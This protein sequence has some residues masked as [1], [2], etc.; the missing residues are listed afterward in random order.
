MKNLKRS[1]IAVLFFCLTLFTF[2]STD[3]EAGTTT[4]NGYLTIQA[5]EVRIAEHQEWSVTFTDWKGGTY[6]V[7]FER[8]RG[9]SWET[10]MTN[11]TNAA[12]FNNLVNEV[13]LGSFNGTYSNIGFTNQTFRD[14]VLGAVEKA[15][16][17]KR[18]TINEEIA[19]KKRLGGG[20]I[21]YTEVAITGAEFAATG[22]GSDYNKLW[23]LVISRLAGAP[24]EYK[25]LA[26]DHS[27][28]A[29]LIQNTANSSTG[30][31]TLEQLSAMLGGQI[32]IYDET[33]TGQNFKV[34]I[35]MLV[36]NWAGS[37]ESHI[38]FQNF[39]NECYGGGWPVTSDPAGARSNAE[40]WLLSKGVTALNSGELFNTGTTSGQYFSGKYV[41]GFE[42]D[43][44]SVG[45]T[46]YAV[47]EPKK[48]PVLGPFN[49]SETATFKLYLNPDKNLVNGESGNYNITITATPAG[50]EISL[51]SPSFTPTN[52]ETVGMTTTTGNT[53]SFA[54]DKKNLNRFSG[55]GTGTSGNAYVTVQFPAPGN[56]A[57][58]GEQSGWASFT[59][60][61]VSAVNGTIDWS[62]TSSSKDSDWDGS[63]TKASWVPS[64]TPP[65]ASDPR[66]INIDWELHTAGSPTADGTLVGNEYGSE[67]WEATTAIPSTENVS[68][69][70]G[71][72]TSM[73]DANG[74]ITATIDGVA[75][76]HGGPIDTVWTPAP[77]PAVTRKVKVTSTVSNIWGMFNP[78]DQLSPTSA[79]KNGGSSWSCGHSGVSC[80]GNGTASHGR[81]EHGEY[82]CPMHPQ[83]SPN[84]VFYRSQ[85]IAGPCN[86]GPPGFSPI[87]GGPDG[88]TQIGES[89]NSESCGCGSCGSH[90]CKW[91]FFVTDGISGA[92]K[93]RED[94]AYS[95][96]SAFTANWINDNVT[97]YDI[98]PGLVVKGPHWNYSGEDFINC[99]QGG[100]FNGRV[101]GSINWIPIANQYYRVTGNVSSNRPNGTEYVSFS[102]NLGSGEPIHQGY[103]MGMGSAS[104]CYENM[105]HPGTH[106]YSI[107]YVETIGNYAYR[108]IANA[109]VYSLMGSELSNIH[110]IN[111]QGGSN[112]G[113]QGAPIVD[114]AAGQSVSAPDMF[115]SLW[116]CLKG[117]SGQ[118][119]SGSGRI[120]FEAWANAGGAPSGVGISVSKDYFL[121]DADVTLTITCDHLYA[122]AC[123]A[124][125]NNGASWVKNISRPNEKN[126][127]KTMNRIHSNYVSSSVTEYLQNE[128]GDALT[129]DWNPPYQYYQDDRSS[130]EYRLR[131][132]SMQRA[133]ANYWQ[134]INSNEGKN[135]YTAN[136]ISDTLCYG[137]N[138]NTTVVVGDIYGVDGGQE[139]VG[140]FNFTMGA[141]EDKSVMDGSKEV[142][143]NHGVSYSAM[144]GSQ[145]AQ[146]MKGGEM[147]I[148]SITDGSHM[149]YFGYSTNGM[150]AYDG[151]DQPYASSL[152]GALR[153]GTL[154]A[155][156]GAGPGVSLTKGD[157]VSSG[158]F[159]GTIDPS[160]SYG[161]GLS[162][163]TLI[164]GDSGDC[165][166]SGNFSGYWNDHQYTGQHGVTFTAKV[167]NGAPVGSFS[168]TNC[169]KHNLAEY[170]SSLIISNLKLNPY[171]PNGSWD[172]CNAKF[173]YVKTLTAQSTNGASA[174]ASSLQ[175]LANKVSLPAHDNIA[176]NGLN[177]QLP[178]IYIY[179]PIST[180]FSQ[181]IGN[182]YGN[183]SGNA[184]LTPDESKYD[185]RVDTENVDPSLVDPYTT[186]T[187]RTQVWITPIGDMNLVDGTSMSTGS[188][189]SSS[190]TGE[191]YRNSGLK[192][193]SKNMNVE[194]WISNWGIKYPHVT[195][196][197][198]TIGE[199]INSYYSATGINRVYGGFRYGPTNLQNFKEEPRDHEFKYGDC[200]YSK[201][202]V[203][204]NEVQDG[205]ISVVAEASNYYVKTGDD[206]AQ[207][208]FTSPTEFRNNRSSNS[209]YTDIEID[210]VGSIGNLAIHD[211]TD[212]RYSNF[213]K[214]NL[215]EYLITGT[216]KKV[217]P[218][219]PLKIVSSAK[220]ILE[221]AVERD[222]N[223][224][225]GKRTHAT[226]GVTD[227][228]IKKADGTLEY[229]YGMGGPYEVLPLV[230]AYNT[231]KE[232]KSEA[233]RLG[234]KV[235]ASVDTVGNYQALIDDGIVYPVSTSQETDPTKDT[236]TQYLE[237]KSHYYLYDFD[238]GKFYAIDLWSGG[239][240]QKSRIYNG[241]TDEVELSR[242]SEAL[243]VNMDEEVSRRNISDTEA[244]VSTTNAIETIGPTAIGA[245][246]DYT[247]YTGH[248]KLDNRNLTYN[249]S[250]FILGDPY[251]ELLDR[252]TQVGNRGQRYHFTQGLTSSTSA[253]YHVDSNDQAVIEAATQ[254]L[255][256]E[257]PHAVIV[258]FNDFIAHGAVWTIRLH[259]SQVNSPTIKF[260]SDVADERPDWITASSYTETTYQ[261]AEVYDRGGTDVLYTIDKELTP[262]VTYEAYKTAADD[263]AVSGT[264]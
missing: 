137:N 34:P 96:L 68:A 141:L 24:T 138:A 48:D 45:G 162:G 5:T 86:I 109:V 49:T 22:N 54:V 183:W 31:D 227:Y 60:Q 94:G 200:F 156:N 213:F 41:V 168:A 201:T 61:S 9:D 78:P 21:F 74:W 47:G 247:G 43:T 19:A 177:I 204:L 263:R 184:S 116:R 79:S 194:R 152:P 238:D 231:I 179:N 20:E 81:Q 29:D 244:S 221:E 171:T 33:G 44:S 100:D 112:D 147:S 243:Y 80:S 144:S 228:Y 99:S 233:V 75:G 84:G 206:T 23:N 250:D 105:V 150:N 130:A 223:T 82:Q 260:F 242:N 97:T 69:V 165:G 76:A 232:F 117:S 170:G 139:G 157:G 58:D 188:E 264:H 261:D 111:F 89:P 218:T 92:N 230:P 56:G 129:E 3:V 189:G 166:G 113:T 142:Y 98:T 257:H 114:S 178:P 52:F 26:S 140:L 107:T 95:T 103:T 50:G 235:L 57:N 225:D 173:H 25:G 220:D 251:G 198:D 77:K 66:F 42:V 211:T 262:L 175:A 180:E 226:L 202:T 127:G 191:V 215:D 186:P 253:S 132:T 62:G 13:C 214:K 59:V 256:E 93:G 133:T 14:M 195:K 119:E 85:H 115:G 110:K 38:S 15:Y 72:E 18:T 207:Y 182:E 185:Y 11:P 2:Y 71:A 187:R 248:L 135:T 176:A 199:D 104:T 10:I 146:L 239:S 73:I 224:R 67:D 30:L 46:Y 53:F 6:T 91:S 35:Y 158:A 212:F 131:V 148:A 259:G 241:K 108:R 55:K 121:G 125:P 87:M 136:V 8:D 40:A 181:V 65:A 169:G 216:V 120:V 37:S 151:G 210:V 63:K 249:G 102:P 128:T 1:I 208:G 234:Y 64:P 149:P 163:S 246:E 237:V 154:T 167:N 7:Q 51:G 4:A 164:L 122:N 245:G 83:G 101:N 240:G 254:R 12:N 160:S 192:G 203:F 88:N 70:L 258:E 255:K 36:P 193:Y 222:A 32:K 172:T 217:D 174:G 219:N 143:R 126:M 124:T 161:G 197:G 159:G 190:V 134:N 196:F 205:L 106:T 252:S 118:Y 145:L 123:V 90:N 27:T 209:C 236:R 16:E 17:T 153:S 155:Y 28:A 229:G 39:I